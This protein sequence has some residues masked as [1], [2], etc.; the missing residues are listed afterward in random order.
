MTND[1]I[2]AVFRNISNLMQ[3]KG[4]D[5]FRVRIYDR[6]ADTIEG[7]STDLRQLADENKLRTVPGIG[8]SIEQMIIEMLQTG[9]STRH[10][11]LTQEMG[12]EILDLLAIRGV[13]PKTAGR[14]YHELGVKNLYDL[15]AAINTGRLNE[16]K[17]MGAKTVASI[18]E[19]LSFVE[20]QRRMRPLW[21]ILP[22]AD[23]ILSRLRSRSEIR[24]L[25]S[26]GELRRR[27]E[28][29][30]RLEFTVEC[31]DAEVIT[32]ALSEA[33]GVTDITVDQRSAQIALCIDEGFP[34]CI[35][36]VAPEAYEAMLFATTGSE[37]H[38][39]RLNQIAVA[40]DLEPIRDG[41]PN[42]LLHRTE[43]QL[44]DE[45]GAPFIVPELRG[46]A[47]SVEAGLKGDLPTLIEYSDLRGD[48]HMHTTWSDGRNSIR[49]MAEAARAL[50]REYA[51]ITD[52]SQSSWVANGLTPERLQHQLELVRE[53][54]AEIDGIEILTGSEVDIRRDGSLDFDDEI[55]AELDIVVASVHAGFTLGETE[56]TERVIR[57]IENPFVMIIGHPTG[58]LLG[59]RPGYAIN[60]D[61]V[62]DAAVSNGVA[63][64]I[65]SS[66]SRLDLGPDVVR[67]AQAKGCMLSI[68]TDAHGA[69]QLEQG[70]FGVNVAR[71]GWLS[72]AD[73]LNTLSLTA[74]K[75][76]RA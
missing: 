9:R 47:D 29:L 18:D 10:D 19:G 61:A 23:V 20:S 33:P 3:I 28:I 5:A 50:G 68:N 54:N 59:R 34:C 45:L 41:L 7:L 39:E 67:K 11:E 72:K 26:T 53:I 73:V 32:G 76:R 66:P 1:E 8:K 31:T 21:K 22:I 48:L 75:A 69:P 63:L 17:R 36:C 71:R 57:A 49:E 13:G 70:P 25:D 12:A 38:L 51:A 58:R 27:E 16:M 24:R 40:R 15:R 4:E 46:S 52:H 44:Y 43:S 64:E 30:Q 56:M 74:L 2:S 60:L 42:W 55:L 6:T 37:A 14:L 62:I 35:Y 65:N